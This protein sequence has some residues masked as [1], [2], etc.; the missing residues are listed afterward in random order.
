MRPD[1][2]PAR[3]RRRWIGAAVAVVVLMAL[4]RVLHHLP[5]FDHWYVYAG[6]AAACLGG[7]AAIAYFVGRAYR[8]R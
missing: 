8:R 2:E 4:S 7:D 5:R 6:L 3:P 1:S